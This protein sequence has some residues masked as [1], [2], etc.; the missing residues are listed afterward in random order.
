ME[1]LAARCLGKQRP[2]TK[3][4]SLNYSSTHPQSISF[5]GVNRRVRL[6]MA[7]NNNKYV[8]GA[9]VAANGDPPNRAAP[10][11]QLERLEAG[12]PAAGV[13]AIVDAV[14]ASIAGR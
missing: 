14:S 3:S 2:E 11:G 7:P 1:R 9:S 5:F 10:I 8:N 12:L 4:R 13:S 6:V